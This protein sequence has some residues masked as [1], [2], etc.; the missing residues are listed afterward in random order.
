M[1]QLGVDAI[2]PVC[3]IQALR[4]VSNA[5]TVLLVELLSARSGP[6]VTLRFSFATYSR[7]V[8]QRHSSHNGAPASYT[9][10]SSTVTTHTASSST[11]QQQVPAAA[12]VACQYEV[13]ILHLSNLTTVTN[14]N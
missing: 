14:R 9:V 12:R 6:P 10:H 3:C 1:C 7:L 11:H 13:S 5:L 2:V 4:K 8:V